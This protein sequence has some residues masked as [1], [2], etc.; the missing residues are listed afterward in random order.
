MDEPLLLGRINSCDFKIYAYYYFLRSMTKTR[1]CK[2][3]VKISTW[4]R[5]IAEWLEPD[6]QCLSRNSPGFDPSIL[7]HS[8]I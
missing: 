7:R 6:C 4:M 2:S 8:G 1:I 5:S 3:A